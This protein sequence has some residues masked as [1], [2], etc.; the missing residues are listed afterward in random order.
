MRRARRREEL[1]TSWSEHLSV[2]TC[3]LCVHTRRAAGLQKD[4]ARGL[5]SGRLASRD[6]AHTYALLLCRSPS[7]GAGAQ[8]PGAASALPAQRRHR[9][10]ATTNANSQGRSAKSNVTR[11]SSSNAVVCWA[12][13]ARR[14]ISSVDVALGLS[15][16]AAPLPPS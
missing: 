9:A 8:A 2:V 12:L 14:L 1:G 7:S 15:L 6:V 16:P 13:A 3:V 11:P 4:I 10:L 5:L